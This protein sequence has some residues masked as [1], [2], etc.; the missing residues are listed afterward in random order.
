MMLWVFILNLLIGFN[1]SEFVN[2][3]LKEFIISL[4][5]KYP[6]REIKLIP[7]HYFHVGGDDREFRSFPNRNQTK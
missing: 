7:M 2:N 3:Q 6:N 1:I 5:N 4:S